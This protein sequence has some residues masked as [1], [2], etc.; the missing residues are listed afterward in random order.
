MGGL[1]PAI[2]QDYETG[3]V[4]ML[5]FMDQKTLDLIDERFREERIAF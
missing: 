4:L 3:D 1:V 2:I 5:A